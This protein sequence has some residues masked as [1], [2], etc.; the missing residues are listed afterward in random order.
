MLQVIARTWLE[1]GI[2]GT[3]PSTTRHHSGVLTRFTD[4]IAVV[5]YFFFDTSFS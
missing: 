4:I 5:E 2:L 3:V 1:N